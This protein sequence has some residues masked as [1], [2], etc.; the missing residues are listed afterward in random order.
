MILLD[1]HTWVW[2]VAKP[3]KLSKKAAKALA[4]ADRLAVSAISCWEV[5]TLVW[6]GRLELDRP[7]RDWMVQALAQEKIELIGL[8]PEIAARSAD[9]GDD[10]HGD[11]ADR[12]LIAT[13]LERR[14]PL[15]TRDRA[16]AA[17]GIVR[18][19]W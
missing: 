13:A 15:V 2:H 5:A 8:S 14:A 16:I 12:I 11:P 1:T 3:E 6:K 7:T 4:D 17:S 9:L 19:V 18:C 10:V